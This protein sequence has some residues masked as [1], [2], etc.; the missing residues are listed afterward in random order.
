VYK[1]IHALCACLARTA[2]FCDLHQGGYDGNAIHDIT[3]SVPNNA[4]RKTFRA[5]RYYA[6]LAMG[7][8][9]QLEI[10]YFVVM[11]LSVIC[12]EQLVRAR[13]QTDLVAR[14]RAATGP[15]GHGNSLI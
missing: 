5:K 2:R 7:N 10:L 15:L 11:G 6:V 12:S 3:P 14:I 9:G 4:S 1:S 8:A 13:S